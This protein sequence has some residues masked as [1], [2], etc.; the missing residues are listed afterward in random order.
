MFSTK[1]TGMD[2]N[3]T[4]NIINI[5]FDSIE[6]ISNQWKPKTTNQIFDIL[7]YSGQM[8]KGFEI[9]TKHA[10]LRPTPVFGIRGQTYTYLGMLIDRTFVSEVSTQYSVNIYQ[11]YLI[12][13]KNGNNSR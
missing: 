7:S 2:N 4:E 9:K 3:K 10:A 1:V 6:N 12:E 13:E 5:S 8:S 11:P